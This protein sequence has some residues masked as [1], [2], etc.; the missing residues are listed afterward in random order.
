MPGSASIEPLQRADDQLRRIISRV[1]PAQAGLPTPCSEFNLRTL[2][3]HIVYDVQAFT[4]VIGGGQRG[5]PDVDRL[6]DNWLGAYSSSADLLL[7]A[8]RSGGTGGTLTSRMSDLP[9]TWTLGQHTSD[10]VVHAWES[11]QRPGI[12]TSSTPNWARQLS[13]GLRELEAG[14][15]RPGVPVP[16]SL[17]RRMHPSTI[18]WQATSAAHQAR[19]SKTPAL[20]AVAFDVWNQLW[21][22]RDARRKSPGRFHHASALRHWVSHAGERARRARRQHR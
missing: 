6:G 7:S 19:L 13:P 16:R 8:W 2:I 21:V 1:S 4:A 9:A 5:S 22:V 3:N 11:P 14:V 17:C 18:D 15:P 20:P 12:P 10:L